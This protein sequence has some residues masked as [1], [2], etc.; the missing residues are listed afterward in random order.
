[1]VRLFEHAT[2]S[3]SLSDHYTVQRL[4][5]YFN[6]PLGLHEDL[7]LEPSPLPLEDARLVSAVMLLT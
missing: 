6:Q 5:L 1:M 7:E 3:M 2:I 4:G